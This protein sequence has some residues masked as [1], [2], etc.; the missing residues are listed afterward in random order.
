M[1]NFFDED[2]IFSE[3]NNNQPQPNVPR[4]QEGLTEFFDLLHRAITS[5]Q[6]DFTFIRSLDQRN[7]IRM[8]YEGYLAV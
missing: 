5:K 3:F 8:E 6:S 4:D 2:N 7:Q 1:S